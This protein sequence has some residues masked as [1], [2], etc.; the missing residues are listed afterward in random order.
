MPL[1]L[2]SA[3]GSVVQFILVTLPFAAVLIYFLYLA[4]RRPTLPIYNLP[5]GYSDDEWNTA[6]EE[7]GT[8]IRMIDML[9]I[10][11]SLLVFWT[12]FTVYI[13]YF[14]PKRRRL[15]GSYLQIGESTVGDVLYDENTRGCCGRVSNDYGYAVYSHPDGNRLV[16]KRV[17]VFQRYTREKIAI[18][19]L[20]NRPLSGQARVSF[21]Q[22]LEY[23][24]YTRLYWD[25]SQFK[26]FLKN[27][28]CAS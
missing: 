3:R 28:F 1:L 6:N 25:V 18:I 20:P 8:L 2:A 22:K 11:L 15:I 7:T 12:M 14:V 17:R 26:S 21:G 16:R 27:V 13:M 9:T 4:Y 19:L 10:F 5:Y 23:Q 24:F